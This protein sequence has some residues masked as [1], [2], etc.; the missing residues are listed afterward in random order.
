M[1][2]PI[3]DPSSNQPATTLSYAAA[4]AIQIPPP[5][6]ARWMAMCATLLYATSMGLP[7]FSLDSFF[8]DDPL[9]GHI[10]I[11]CAEETLRKLISGK[12]QRLFTPN[13]YELLGTVANLAF[14]A[15]VVSYFFLISRGSRKRHRSLVLVV[16]LAAVAIV[17]VC[18]LGVGLI[19]NESLSEFGSGIYAWVFSMLLMLLAACLSQAASRKMR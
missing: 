19:R 3:P 18:A 7:V 2:E 6:W 9:G 1:D 4:G 11:D 13:L 12:P 5:P 14:I 16:I 10:A 15:A 17:C 8:S